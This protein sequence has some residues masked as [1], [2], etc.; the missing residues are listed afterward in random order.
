MF[1]V[2]AVARHSGI[3]FRHPPARE[4]IYRGSHSEP[5]R[6]N[7]APGP[8]VKRADAPVRISAPT[9]IGHTGIL[10]KRSGTRRI[11]PDRFFGISPPHRITGSCRRLRPND[12]SL[13]PDIQPATHPRYVEWNQHRGPWNL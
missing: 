11:L 12:V 8:K 2:S 10:C 9:A 3:A 5:L 13:C 7:R 1:N 6:I 4:G